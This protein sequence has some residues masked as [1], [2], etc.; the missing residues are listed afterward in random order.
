MKSSSDG[1]VS[2]TAGEAGQIKTNKI[3][4]SPTDTKALNTSKYHKSRLDFGWG[5]GPKVPET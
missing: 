3:Q 5:G 4:I 1:E 2:R